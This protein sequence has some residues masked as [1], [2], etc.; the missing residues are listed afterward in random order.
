MSLDMTIESA[1]EIAGLVGV[2]PGPFTP[3]QLWWMSGDGQ[4]EQEEVKV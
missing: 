1:Y 4:S 3:R 2:D